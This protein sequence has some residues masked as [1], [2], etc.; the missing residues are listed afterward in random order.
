[1]GNDRRHRGQLFCA[2][3][4][5]VVFRMGDMRAVPRADADAYV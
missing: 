3:N 5:T 4:E 2:R 1:M